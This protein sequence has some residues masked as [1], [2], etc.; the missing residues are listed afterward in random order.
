MSNL[1]MQRLA[2]KKHL[3]PDKHLAYDNA[4]HLISY[5][6]LPTTGLSGRHPLTGASVTYGGTAAGTAFAR[7]DSWH[8]VLTFLKES[9]K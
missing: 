5:P 4:G 1:V 6:F 2:D 8:Q 7:S 3:Y 9:L